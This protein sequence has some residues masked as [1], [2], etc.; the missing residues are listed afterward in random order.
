MFCPKCRVEYREG[1]TVCAD[2]DILLVATLPPEQSEGQSPGEPDIE[3]TDLEPIYISAEQSDLLIA[4]S[5][6]DSAGISSFVDSG[7]GL[8]YSGIGRLLVRTN[9]VEAALEILET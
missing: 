6:L 7:T 1:F 4:R 8:T 2:C 5:L 3:Y 9:D